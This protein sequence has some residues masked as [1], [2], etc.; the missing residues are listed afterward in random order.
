MAADAVAV[1]NL[2]L[3]EL[4]ARPMSATALT[5]PANDVERAAAIVYPEVR[6]ECLASHPWGFTIVKAAL[7]APT[8]PL[9]R[10]KWEFALP[11]LS[12]VILPG[13]GPLAVFTAAGAGVA[14]LTDWMFQ[15]GKVQAN[16]ALLWADLQ[17]R[18][19]E[20]DWPPLFTK[21]VT[22]ALAA[23][24]ANPVTGIASK[25]VEKNQL[26]FG[27][28]SDNGE[29]GALGLAKRGLSRYSP[30][31]SFPVQSN[32]FSDARGVG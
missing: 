4:E 14:P 9:T 16:E 5:A 15:N 12:P 21:F 30:P 7:T 18:K 10:Y 11:V 27:N 31:R 26:A 25:G 3:I 22:L 2:A 29:G 23:R 19:A 17:V 13:T 6:D 20:S 1:V 8:A 32:P 24:L 28:P